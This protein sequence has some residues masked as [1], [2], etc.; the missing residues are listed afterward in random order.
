MLIIVGSSINQL[1]CF[2]SKMIWTEKS[3]WKKEKEGKRL[4]GVNESCL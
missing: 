1:N 4:S 2:D 3:R